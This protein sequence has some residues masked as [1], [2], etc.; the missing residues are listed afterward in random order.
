M[1]TYIVMATIEYR[2]LGIPELC[3][4]PVP[5]LNLIESNAE[6]KIKL[7]VYCDSSGKQ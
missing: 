5:S 4:I 6:F 3:L 2:D 7:N 1:H